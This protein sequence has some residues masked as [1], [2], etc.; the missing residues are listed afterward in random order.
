MIKTGLGIIADSNFFAAGKEAGQGAVN[1]L[2]EKPD[3]FLVTAPFVPDGD[4]I[5]AGIASDFPNIPIA[6]GTTGW[7]AITNKGIKE[8][9]VV[10]LGMKFDKTDFQISYVENLSK[11]A[12]L[13]GIVLAEKLLITHK[14]SPLFLL[15]FVSGLGIAFDN[16]LAGLKSV[17][18][19]KT[20]VLGGGTGDSMALKSG[21][22]QFY[23]NQLL[24]DS[25]VGLGL[26]GSV[27]STIK[28][29]HGWE[30]LGLEMKIT[31]AENIFVSEIDGK[32]AVKIFE[33]YFDKAEVRDPK[34]FSPQGQGILY[35]LGIISKKSEK[36]IVR[37]VV[38]IGPKGELIFA[39]NMPQNAIV[40]IMQ[41][42]TNKMIDVS[43]SI[44]KNLRE[45]LS[46]SPQVAFVFDC[47]T[48]KLLLAPDQQKEID[49]FEL[50]LNKDIPIFGFFSY[51]EVCSEKNE[52]DWF[53]HNETFTAGLLRE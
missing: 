27:Q 16:F 12:R 19:N 31:K 38:G 22:N 5:L 8:K 37:Q 50:G 24:S 23:N 3:L 41:A 46:G 26:W 42:Q 52:E 21:G 47:V 48:R 2:G 33:R 1:I 15:L 51:G 32:P 53:V 10:V 25:A 43:G 30:P 17:L 11:D 4:K 49:A 13:A 29:G 9:E 39:T 40:R 45:S 34:F 18:G 36:I 44:G 28:A 7:G 6:G 20:N 35:P 14:T